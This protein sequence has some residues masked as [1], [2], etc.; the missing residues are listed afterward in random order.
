MRSI[1]STKMFLF[2]AIVLLF[3]ASIVSALVYADTVYLKNGRSL[4]GIIE[5]EDADKVELSVGFGAVTFRKSAIERISKSNL[6]EAEQILKKWEEKK[7]EEK[8]ERLEKEFEPKNVTL[9]R[10]DS[11]HIVVDTLLN[12]SV[13]A[14]LIFDTGASLLTITHAV[15]LKLGINPDE[16]NPL[17][18]LQVA[19]GEKVTAKFFVLESVNVEDSEA[20][21][22]EAAIMPKDVQNIG[23]SDGLLGMSFLRKFNFRVDQKKNKLILEKLQE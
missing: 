2:A 4:E 12:G 20:K 10:E 1:P 14:K 6:E 5:R 13:A 8:K 17:V 23:P 11:G 21:N 19:N 16:I 22:V 18:E 3:L 15:A 7:E 9:T